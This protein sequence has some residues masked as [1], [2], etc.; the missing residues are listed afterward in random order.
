MKD[1]NDI[2]C[3]LKQSFELFDTNKGNIDTL[4]L[5][6]DK[7]GNFKFN[8]LFPVFIEPVYNHMHLTLFY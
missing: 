3:E 7:E 5:L 6:Q 4:L 2:Y 8:Q 1:K